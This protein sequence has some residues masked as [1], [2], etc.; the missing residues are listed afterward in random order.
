MTRAERLRQIRELVDI[1]IGALD[2]VGIEGVSPT[3][4]YLDWLLADIARLEGALNAIRSIHED[5]STGYKE[6]GGKH[7]ADQAIKSWLDRA[8]GGAA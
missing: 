3:I 8:L 7:A 6:N 2:S 5:G 4:V 1:N